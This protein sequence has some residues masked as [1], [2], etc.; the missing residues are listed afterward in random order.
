MQSS[1]LLYVSEVIDGDTVK[2]SNGQTLRYIGIDTPEIR[3]KKGGSFEYEPQPFA[4][5]AKKLNQALVEAK[6]VRIEFDVQ[7]YD[8]YQRLLGYCFV[9]EEFINAKL[10]R[11]GLA[12][13]YTYPPN[14][15]YAELFVAAQKEARQ[16]K[17]GIWG[18]YETIDH[19]QAGNYLDQIRT[20]RGRV[21]YSYQSSKCLFLNFGSDWKSDFTVVIFN[22][23]ID[24]FRKQG[25][26]PLTFYK[27]KVIEVSGRIRSYNGPEIIVNSPAEITVVEP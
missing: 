21:L 7:R 6:E 18:S 11:E 5:E 24:L 3:I 1:D 4:L 23:V 13:L 27:G 10:L 17:R 22:N 12:V 16:N 25:I 26:D 9:G 2:L 19:S 20:V 14:V 15:K 8:R